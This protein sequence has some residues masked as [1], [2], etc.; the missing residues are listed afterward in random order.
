[1]KPKVHDSCFVHKTAVIIGNVTIG[2]NSGIWPHAVVRGDQNHIVIGNNSNVQDCCVVHVDSA[3]P[4]KLGDNVSLGHGAVVHG[5]IIEDNVI[6]GMK[7]VVMN[8]SVIGQGSVI[9][10]GA[11]VK[12]GAK[13]PANSLVVGVPG[14]VVREGDPSLEEYAIKNAQTYVKL[15]HRHKD[16]EFQEY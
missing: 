16:G 7:A 3:N 13:I 1:M 4:A 8:G 11:L 5:A 14:K 15:A 12:E 9:A 2:E 10:A 6:V